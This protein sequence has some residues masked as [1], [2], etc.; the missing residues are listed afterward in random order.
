MKKNI[1]LL[2]G[3]IF[4]AM[5][6]S[7]GQCPTGDLEFRS[8][9]EVNQFIQEYPNCT[10]IN[11]DLHIT[12]VIND[13]SGLS[14]IQ[15]VADTLW[16]RVFSTLEDSIELSL[17][18]LTSI[19]TELVCFHN[20][21][22]S[23]RLSNLTTIGGTM[24]F[25][26]NE[27]LHVDFNS[28]DSVGGNFSFS[29]NFNFQEELLDL[30]SIDFSN[31]RT[32][33]GTFSF[34]SNFSPPSILGKAILFDVP[35]PK[36][37]TVAGDCIFSNN[38]IRS[39]SCNNLV[40]VQGDFKIRNNETLTNVYFDR[41]AT[42][43][44]DFHISYSAITEVNSFYRLSQVGGDFALFHND[45]LTDCSGFCSLF[46]SSGVEGDL[47]IN[48]NP[49]ACNSETT[50]L[51]SC[52]E[53]PSRDC[54]FPSGLTASEVGYSS[55]QLKWEANEENSYYQTRI[56]SNNG[57][58]Q[59]G[60][61][62]MATA[63]WVGL[64][65]CTIY[66][67]Q[68]RSGC[69]DQDE[70]II[71]GNY[72]ASIFVT[73]EG[74]QDSYCYAY[75]QPWDNWI[76]KITLD[77]FQNQSGN[78]L[79]HG[80]FIHLSATLEREKN[81]PLFI[82]P[83]YATIPKE[84]AYY[85]VWIDF[86]Q[87]NDFEDDGEQVIATQHNNQEVLQAQITIPSTATLGST[88]MRIS[89]GKDQS[90]LPCDIGTNSEVEEYTVIIEIPTLEVQPSQ[91]D[92]PASAGT[93]TFSIAAN[94]DWVAQS[95]A[96]WFSFSP[97]SGSTEETIT[98]SY[99]ANPQLIGRTA[100]ITLT[101]NEVGTT[102]LLITQAGNTSIA[103]PV[104][105]VNQLATGDNNGSSWD[106]AYTSLQIAISTARLGE[107]WVAEGTYL[108]THTKDRSISFEVHPKVPLFG[109]F[110]AIGTPK[111]EDRDW[112]KYPT[113]LS[114]DIGKKEDSSDNTNHVV[115]LDNRTT[116]DTTIDG[117]TISGG[118][119]DYAG[120][121]AEVG[122]AFNPKSVF[123][124]KNC[125]FRDNLSEYEGG[126]ISSDWITL[127]V[128]NCQFENNYADYSG[129]AINYFS[130]HEPTRVA[131]L[132]IT[133]ST[134]TSNTARTGGA[135][136]SYGFSGITNCVFSENEAGY[137]GGAIDLF[138]GHTPTDITQFHILNC[139]FS[140]NTAGY[141]GGAVGASGFSRMVGC[142]FVEN[143]AEHEGGAIS[144]SRED[145]LLVTNCTF[146]F[147][148]AERQGAAI[149]NFSWD[150][151]FTFITNSVFYENL[152]GNNQLF[153]FS[154]AGVH[155]E[156]AYSLIDEATCP[157]GVVC[158]EGMIFDS[159]SPFIDAESNDFRPK[160]G[161]AL[162]N[163]GKNSY[164]IPLILVDLANKPRIAN[165]IIDI[166]A[167]E[168]SF[169]ENQFSTNIPIVETAPTNSMT[170]FPNPAH[171]QCTVLL[172]QKAP[173]DLTGIIR[174]QYG[175]E[176]A[177]FFIKEGQFSTPLLLAEFPEGVYWI[178]L[179]GNELALLSS[180]KLLV[181]RSQR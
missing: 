166:G 149:S 136:N 18:N 137:G 22:K 72:S 109:G 64:P 21:L 142:L 67:I 96:T 164:L 19:G 172:K 103:R 41:L 38:N 158:G 132:N 155:A 105:Y 86:N 154:G 31:L 11:G 43:G 108:P 33:G 175:Q 69:L 102:T 152:A 144:H 145:S 115:S 1:I 157:S 97:S 35:F 181:I 4:M 44:K 117:F 148:I 130:G 46:R 52:S 20:T 42:V 70:N 126:A 89:L 56:R 110:A 73:T 7:L 98:L 74:C 39:I 10:T 150:S 34:F 82:E 170:L 141:E 125:L 146:A 143:T 29:Q 88:R 177:H 87:D 121:G 173:T 128:E 6:S 123:T 120:G 78:N 36:L 124:F 116:F 167:Y 151:T 24:D 13:L 16:I 139:I 90:P 17:P 59:E 131:Q 165:D 45:F 65:P 156:I 111:W 28:L 147:N 162:V 161:G 112:E 23:L 51:V 54:Y 94:K 9:W 159:T 169:E 3:F 83:N 25:F 171:Q 153:D 91:I 93:T 48:N 114:G 179:Q 66:E 180:G 53:E 160:E 63:D 40:Q 55:I 32:V 85:S 80:N 138:S 12:G 30:P 113:I 127:K 49:L 100:S 57:A 62:Q 95:D 77:T 133:N 106:N 119:A 14:N 61:F 8:Q 101:G 2:V 92:L 134:F 129:G 26:Q 5:T 58:W 178:T 122:S 140:N 37:H 163:N 107:I 76:E 99:D 135:I 174:N 75:G 79:G 84:D 104:T 176:V 81:Y 168:F 60:N 15:H 27:I 118:N 71:G 50:L 47:I 68:V